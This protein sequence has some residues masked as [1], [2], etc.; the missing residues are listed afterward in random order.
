M[1]F[2]D[3]S[4]KKRLLVIFSISAIVLLI[5]FGDA[6]ATSGKNFKYGPIGKLVISFLDID[7]EQQARIDEILIAKQPQ[8]KAKFN[9][10]IDVREELDELIDSNN[11][12]EAE[13]R[14][15]AKKLAVAEE[16]V[17]V[18]RA[19]LSSEIKPILN[20]EQQ[21]KIDNF[22]HNLFKRIRSLPILN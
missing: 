11:A 7:Q 16:E 15:L 22:R 19:E 13:I 14:D 6:Y 18:L 1:E 17:L 4:N 12:N 20:S 3:L 21:E 9:A 5:N 2:K 8:I 10:V